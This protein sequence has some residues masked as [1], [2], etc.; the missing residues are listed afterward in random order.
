MEIGFNRD[1]EMG[2]ERNE[3]KGRGGEQEDV[4]YKQ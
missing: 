2:M 3:G 1:E 4:R